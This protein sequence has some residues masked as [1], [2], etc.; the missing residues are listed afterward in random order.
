MNED[1]TLPAPAGTFDSHVPS[2]RTTGRAAL[3]R[4]GSIDDDEWRRVFEQDEYDRAFV[5][6]NSAFYGDHGRPLD[7]DAW[8]G[9]SRFLKRTPMRVRPTMG[10]ESTGRIIATWRMGQEALSLEF[11]DRFQ[12]KFAVTAFMNGNLERRWGL[13]HAVSLFDQEPLAARFTE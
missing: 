2:R 11:L 3:P 6:L 1:F 13:G 7:A 8:S 9:L 12:L 4:T 10:A 5:E